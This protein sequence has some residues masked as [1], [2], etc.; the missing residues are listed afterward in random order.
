MKVVSKNE[1][2]MSEKENDGLMYLLGENED[3]GLFF[4]F[5]LYVPKECEKDTNV[6]FSCPTPRTER[7]LS[8]LESIDNTVLKNSKSICPI[9]RRLSARYH[10]PMIIPVIPRIMGL[11]T[12]YLGTDVYHNDFHEVKKYIREGVCNLREED[13][14]NFKDIHKQVCVMI[15]KALEFLS[16]LGYNPDS[17]V[18]ID[19]YSAGSKFANFFTALHPALVKMIIGGGSAGLIIRPLKEYN[20]YTLNYPVGI[21]DLPEFDL[22]GFKQIQQFYYIG[23]DDENDVAMPKCKMDPVNKDECGNRIPLLD[24]EGKRIY[25][26]D[27]DGNYEIFYQEGYYSK[28]DINAINKG[29][30]DN[31]QT[32]FDNAKEIYEELGIDA[33]FKRYPGNHRTLFGQELYDDVYEQYERLIGKEYKK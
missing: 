30:S 21:N 20:G 9:S 25:I 10:L 32:R 16:E 5:L 28:Y 8:F 27:S 29:L 22:E 2:S 17:K 26:M 11:D 13:L 15:E 14:D 31:I 18:I 1:Y 6:I 23:G 7:E 3:K 33:V 4:P 24:D 19:G 12:S